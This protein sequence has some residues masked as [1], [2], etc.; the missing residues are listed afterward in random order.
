MPT[1]RDLADEVLLR[2]WSFVGRKFPPGGLLLLLQRKCDELILKYARSV[3]PIV[4]EARQ[5]AGKVAGILVGLTDGGVP[6]YLTTSDDGWPVSVTALGTP[7]FDFTQ[8]KIATDPLGASSAAP[9][10]PFPADYLKMI[11]LSVNY[12][13]GRSGPVNIVPEAQRHAGPQ[14]RDPIAYVSGNRAVPIRAPSLSGSADEW[15]SVTSVRLSY[16]KRIPFSAMTSAV[17][18]P[19]VLAGAVIAAV[20]SDLARS[21]Q[22][23]QVSSREKDAFKAEA[24]EMEKTLELA[25]DH[26]LGDLRNDS[27]LYSD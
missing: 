23:E 4:G 22:V 27:V 24:I 6:Y 15:T 19:S 18:V 5:V 11:A 12:A 13:D 14:G 1:V 7:Y 16:I 20:V 3:E 26:L 9:G 8:P 25:G 10:F 2:H 21:A 17:R